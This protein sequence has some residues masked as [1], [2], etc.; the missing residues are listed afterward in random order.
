[1]LL[2]SYIHIA[3]WSAVTSTSTHFVLC[4]CVCVRAR[5][6]AC[7]CACVCVCVQVVFRGGLVGKTS[8]MAVPSPLSSH[9]LSAQDV[10]S[11]TQSPSTSTGTHMY[12]YRYI[13]THIRLIAYSKMAFNH[14][15][16]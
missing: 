2:H 12:I 14:D 8:G 3:C 15:Y 9:S 6:Y 7:V 1:M 5:V 4:V 13:D 10:A 11:K 16:I